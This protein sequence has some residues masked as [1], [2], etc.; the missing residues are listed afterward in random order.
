MIFDKPTKVHYHDLWSLFRVGEL[1][2]LNQ[3][4]SS[5][6]LNIDSDSDSDDEDGEYTKIGFFYIDHDGEEF[7]AVFKAFQFEPY[8]GE[9]DV[10]TLPIY[11]LRFSK[12]QEKT[13]RVC[14]ARGEKFQQIMG[15]S[16]R[17]SMSYDGWT[18]IQTPLGEIIKDTDSRYE[19]PNS[20]L[21]ID[22]DI[23]IDFREAYQSH[24]WWEPSFHTYKKEPF[25]PQTVDDNLAI[26]RWADKDRT[27]PVHR[28]YEV[29]IDKN[30]IPNL[31]YHE[32]L[33]RPEGTL[34]VP[35]EDRTAK[36]I[37][38][39]AKLSEE[40]L[41]LLPTRMFAYAFRER[42]FFHAN[43]RCI[44]EKSAPSDTHK[45]FIQSVVHGHFQKKVAQKQSIE[46]ERE[47]SDQDFIHGKGRGLVIL[48]HG[49]P[50]VGKTATAEAISQ[51][52]NKPLFPITCGN[53]GT[54][55]TEVEKT[56]IGLFRLANLWDCILLL[57]EAEIFLSPRERTDDNLQRNALVSGEAHH[58]LLGNCYTELT[59][60]SV[61]QNS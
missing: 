44:K 27:D 14:K 49:A 18:L 2:L 23:I 6:G 10:T 42:K 48:L 29:V 8:D 50:G 53:L 34:F 54:V 47:I 22:S 52:H 30:E 58:V 39:V 61:P 26:I 12:D 60:P 21:Y 32:F 4:H 40:D 28:E 46:Q 15:R 55:P 31:E 36:Q 51:T 3:R 43:I 57:D 59:G 35:A 45:N 11:S 20:P 24:P 41:L 19:P 13:E 17:H 5:K 25:M 37:A 9:K 7:G 33:E 38:A 56:L 1:V 16:T